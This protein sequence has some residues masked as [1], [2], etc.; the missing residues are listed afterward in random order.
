[1]IL[2]AKFIHKMNY[3]N[4][5]LHS[6]YSVRDGLNSI[7]SIVS[8]AK[9][10]NQSH[11]AI[12]DH[13]SLSGLYQLYTKSKEK[14]LNSVFGEEVYV[15]PH[16]EHL[17]SL[18]DKLDDFYPKQ[19]TKIQAV[20]KMLGRTHHLILLAQ[21][22]KG[23]KN[24][25]KIHNDAVENGYYYRPRTTNEFIWEHSEGLIASSACLAGE[26]PQLLMS[27]NERAAE[28]VVQQYID[29]FGKDN[30]FIELMIINMPLQKTLNE[31]LCRII[32]KFDI[33]PLITLDS[34]YPNAEDFE[35]HKI[36]LNMDAIKDK[37]TL[38]Q[39]K[40]EH[41]IW[42]FD[43]TD[44]YQKSIEQIFFDY[45]EQHRSDIFNKKIF[46]RGIAN[47]G[48]ICSQIQQVELEH[49]PR[50]PRLYE[51]S[52][53]ELI[54]RCKK[55]LTDKIKSG[56]I[57]ENKLDEYKERL[58]TELKVINRIG[59]EDYLLILSNISR[60][61]NNPS[62]PANYLGKSVPDWIPKEPIIKGPGRGSAVGS[63]V[64]W[65]IDI[66]D[67]DPIKHN[68]LFERFLDVNR[69]PQ[70]MLE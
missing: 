34:H 15:S 16:R 57:F 6:V 42:E 4:F 32:E 69:L 50:L 47:T 5:H 37:K 23:Y 31:K 40:Q 56:I 2:C 3:V 28:K 61:C 70:L 14:G 46:M 58:R 53:K 62:D 45:E 67:V 43:A 8:K 68:L 51:N 64:A 25:L 12:T 7:D 54:I 52:T 33:Q 59:A 1:M 30:F 65:L 39:L 10:R 9:E 36:L 11:V 17:M 20:R 35:L 60:F 48:F 19:E 21:N 44:L 66:T 29:V 49:A 26:I 24:L 41:T 22:D 63:I 55:G 27:G 13:G 18:K 38:E